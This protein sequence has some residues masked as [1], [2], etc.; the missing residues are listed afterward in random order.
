MDSNNIVAA[1]EDAKIESHQIA[2]KLIDM[3]KLQQ[4]KSQLDS[5]IAQCQLLL[6]IKPEENRADALFD[7]PQI[8]VEA[9]ATA[10]P[11]H[12]LKYKKNWEK[13]RG[14]FI[15]TGNRHMMLSELTREFKKRGFEL[16]KDNAKEVV[17]SAVRNKPDIFAYDNEAFTY[18]LKDF[19]VNEPS[20]EERQ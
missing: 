17:R 5:F 3:E 8:K 11:N 10:K 1:M 20:L 15:E 18:W 2:L 14:I 16:S 13:A 6:N 7:L 19:S 9:T 12:K 4:R